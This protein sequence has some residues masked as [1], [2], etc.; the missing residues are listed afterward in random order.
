MEW[1][2]KVAAGVFLCFLILVPVTAFLLP[3]HETSQCRQ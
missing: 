2:K 3:D 1:K